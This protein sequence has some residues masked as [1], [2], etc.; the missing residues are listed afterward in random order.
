MTPAMTLRQKAS[1]TP[2]T[3]PPF[4]THPGERDGGGHLGRVLHSG[5]FSESVSHDE[6]LPTLGEYYRGGL[7][8]ATEPA[9]F[10][11]ATGADTARSRGED[12]YA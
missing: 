9:V 11:G 8:L 10:G 7:R 5:W 1:M 3:H 6:P 4:C 2:E 12:S